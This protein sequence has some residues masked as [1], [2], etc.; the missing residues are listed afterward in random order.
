MT[1]HLLER[2]QRIPAPPAEVFDFFAEARNL[3]EITPPWLH[4]RITQAPDPVQGGAEI[5]YRLRLHGIPIRWVSRIE[6]WEPPHRFADTQISGP[7][8]HWHHTHTVEADGEG[9]LMR[10]RV[11]YSLPLGPVG[12]LAH[13]LLVRRDL[14]RIFDFRR[15][16]IERRFGAAAL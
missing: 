7:Y 11:R 16:A 1:T 3:E 4:F 12:E 10:D 2:S 15:E 5:S 13:R 9:V 8:R 14:D 6:D